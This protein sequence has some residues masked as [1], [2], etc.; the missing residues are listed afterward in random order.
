MAEIG[1]AKRIIVMGA[2]IRATA[3][4]AWLDKVRKVKVS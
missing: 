4:R 3:C 1:G 2:N